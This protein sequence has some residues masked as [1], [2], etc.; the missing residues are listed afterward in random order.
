MESSSKES[1]MMLALEAMK[2]NPY[3]IIRAA[4]K[5]YEVPRTTLQTRCAGV[6]SRR[7]IPANSTKLTLIEETMFLETILDL[8]TR[9]FQARLADVAAMADR[10][11]I[12]R[13]VSRVGT[14][15]A[16]HF[17]KRHPELT[18]RFRRRIDYQR[19]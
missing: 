7:D 19:A 17:V 12:D 18:T 2:N 6:Q 11:R 14:R 3:L 16:E 15:W 5:L 9:G 1:R 10:L 8:D 4:A 13:Y